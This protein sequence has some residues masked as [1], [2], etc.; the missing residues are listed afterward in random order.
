MSDLGI[1]IAVHVLS[2]VWWIGGIA[3]VACVFLPALRAGAVG[4]PAA[5]FRAIESRFAPQA[6]IAVIL[7]GLSGGYLL[8]RLELW[9]HLHHA[10]WWW[11]DAM[12]LYWL[13]FVMFLFVLAPLGL[14]RH[15]MRGAHPDERGW[16]RLQ[17]SHTLLLS[18]G[19]VIIA[20]AA[21]GGRGF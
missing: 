11:L 7:V 21:A 9:R 3:F 12:M 13:L 4:D 18:I 5:A 15:I 19:L 10:A 6:R 8:W 16:R 20:A 14:L 17:R 2:V 1:A